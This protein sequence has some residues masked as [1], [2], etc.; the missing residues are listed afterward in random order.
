[1]F[2]SFIIPIVIP[3][4]ATFDGNNNNK[5]I[6]LSFSFRCEIV[7]QKQIVSRDNT[8]LWHCSSEDNKTRDNG[9]SIFRRWRR[10][11]GGDKGENKIWFISYLFNALNSI[12][13]YV[14][15][16]WTFVAGK[17]KRLESGRQCSKRATRY[18]F[19]KRRLRVVRWKFRM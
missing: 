11:V 16:T 14:L 12:F 8:G 2:L 19:D 13:G 17:S 6:S 3:L 18:G 1:M 4:R 10:K 9:T 5:M 15:C 7:E